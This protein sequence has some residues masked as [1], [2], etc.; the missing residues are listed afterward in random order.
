MKIYKN[1]SPILIT[2]I[3]F[4]LI[5]SFTAQSGDFP[6]ELKVGGFLIGPQAYSFNRY[7]FF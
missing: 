5:F 6:P 1:I 7:S 3:T 4:L 2:I